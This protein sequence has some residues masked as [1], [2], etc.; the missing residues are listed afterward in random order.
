MLN[1]FMKI[2]RS[3][4][5]PKV[6]KGQ[7]SLLRKKMEKVIP[8][9]QQQLID[10]RKKWGDESLGEITV[11]QVIGGMRGMKALFYDTSK[12]DPLLVTPALHPHFL[13]Y[14]GNHVPRLQYPRTHGEHPQ[15][16]RKPA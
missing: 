2:G 8:A 16:W 4:F 13:T 6:F 12:L 9:K 1:K 14:K 11:D 10:I 5:L 7:F 15:C 3:S